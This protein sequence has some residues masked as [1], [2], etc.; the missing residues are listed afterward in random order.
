MMAGPR[1]ADSPIVH[2]LRDICFGQQNFCMRRAPGC[3]LS[4]ILGDALVEK[5]LHFDTVNLHKSVLATAL[6]ES[7]SFIV[8]AHTHTPHTFLFFFFFWLIR[9]C[10]EFKGNQFN[11]KWGDFTSPKDESVCFRSLYRKLSKHLGSDPKS[12]SL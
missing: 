9:S 3:F 10:K 4:K 8:P 11:T 6:Q 1:S 5:N 7:D 12:L 2:H